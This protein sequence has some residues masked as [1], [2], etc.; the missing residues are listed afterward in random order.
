MSTDNKFIPNTK[1]TYKLSFCEFFSNFVIKLKRISFFLRYFVC[2]IELPQVKD[3][4]FLQ[5]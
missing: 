5:L 2:R 1:T 3:N 4:L